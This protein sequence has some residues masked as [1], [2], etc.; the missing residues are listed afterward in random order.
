MSLDDQQ[1]ERLAGRLGTRAEARLDP[2]RVAEGVVE[3]LRCAP[4]PVVWWR[5]MPAL[6]AL[7]AAAV[8]VLAIGIVADNTQDVGD[9]DLAF[10]ETPA[11]L[12]ELSVDELAEVYDSLSFSA[13]VYEFTNAGLEDLSV[14]QLE[15]LLR[16]MMED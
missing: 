9:V 3:R 15:E 16:T 13:P 6:S 1:L 11:E 8:L 4:S 10:A 12:Q 14:G 2:E 5:R 7:A